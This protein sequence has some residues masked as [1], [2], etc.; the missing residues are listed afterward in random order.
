MKRY[1]YRKIIPEDLELM[2]ILR[3]AGLFYWEIGQVFGISSNTA[4][5]HLSPREKMMTIKRANKLN[6]K[7][8]KKQK[9]EKSRK[10]A[11]Y[12]KQY[13]KERYNNDEEFRKRFIGSMSRSQKR[14][15][16]QRRKQGLCTKCGGKRK[17]KKFK[18]CENCR[19]KRMNYDK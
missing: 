4:I 9:R 15:R 7:M 8:T 6:N 16:D 10:K 13:M 18:Q 19:V 3:D 1:R 5:Y 12:R 14:I 2:K 17:D 11:P